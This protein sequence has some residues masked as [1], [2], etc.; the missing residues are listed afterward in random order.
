MHQKTCHRDKHRKREKKKETARECRVVKGK[1]KRIP[2]DRWIEPIDSLCIRRRRPFFLARYL[3][4]QRKEKK[5]RKIFNLG[6]L[7]R[8]EFLFFLSVDDFFVVPVWPRTVRAYH[9]TID[10][11]YRE[12]RFIS[13]TFAYGNHTRGS[14]SERMKK[15]KK[16]NN[17][18]LYFFFARYPQS[19]LRVLMKLFFFFPFFFK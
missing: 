19:H 6:W 18:G 7:S 11:L 8:K 17:N 2:R 1:R 10:R 14:W 9:Q 3:F 16:N 15:K 12:R 5:S 13:Q 4:L